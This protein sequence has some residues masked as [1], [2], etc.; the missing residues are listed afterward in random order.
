[1]LPSSKKISSST[2]ILYADSMLIFASL[3]HKC[4]FI[5]VL[6]MCYVFFPFLPLLFLWD[7]FCA[8]NPVG[9]GK[10][11][12]ASGSSGRSLEYIC[13]R[14]QFVDE[15]IPRNLNKLILSPRDTLARIHIYMEDFTV[16]SI[17]EFPSYTVRKLGILS[18]IL[19]VILFGIKKYSL[20]WN[21]NLFWTPSMY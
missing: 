9:K 19:V 4:I 18:I 11:S 2:P 21:Y 12:H 20:I 8:L 3:P 14:R 15:W 17:E 1:M 6:F 7:N 13:S 16:Q 5:M 10:S